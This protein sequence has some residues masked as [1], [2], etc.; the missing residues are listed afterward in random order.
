MRCT[1]RLIL[2]NHGS[3]LLSYNSCISRSLKGHGIGPGMFET[4]GVS[5]RK[6][7]NVECAV[8]L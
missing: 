5:T 3:V 6:C 1:R 2:A 7:P 8:Y 4:L